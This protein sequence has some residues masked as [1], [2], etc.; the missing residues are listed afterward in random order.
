[1]HDLVRELA[2]QV[3]KNICHNI[4]E[5]RNLLHSTQEAGR[6][7]ISDCVPAKNVIHSTDAV[8]VCLPADVVSHGRP[9]CNK[10]KYEV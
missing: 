1:M 6:H 9:R 7:C 10:N 2:L 4:S 8:H 3:Y 5:R